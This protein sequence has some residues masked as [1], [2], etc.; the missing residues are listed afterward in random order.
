MKTIAQQ[1]KVT[2][3]PFEITDSNN[4]IIYCEYSSGEWAKHEFDLNNHQIYFENSK[5]FWW[6]QEWDSANNQIYFEKSDGYWSKKEWDATGLIYF[7]DSNGE[8][9]DNRPKT[10]PEFTMKELMEKFTM[11]ELMEKFTM[12]ELIAKVGYEFKIKK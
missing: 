10:I 4:N 11:K 1:L 12:E 9:I 6:K 7:E 2:K 3:F 8:V 5:G